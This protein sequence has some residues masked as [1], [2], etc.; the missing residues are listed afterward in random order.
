MDHTLSA[1]PIEQFISQF[2]QATQEASR[3]KGGDEVV[4]LPNLPNGI[5]EQDIGVLKAMGMMNNGVKDKR[6]VPFRILMYISHIDIMQRLVDKMDE[7]NEIRKWP[8][9][10]Q[11]VRGLIST[12]FDSCLKRV[13]VTA[14]EQRKHVDERKMVEKLLEIGIDIAGKY[15]QL[16]KLIDTPPS[17]ANL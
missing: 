5:V 11:S 13:L 4:E 10:R 1:I 12:E 3:L 14:N 7:I 9:L 17:A 2:E 16:R 15:I 8:E 6:L